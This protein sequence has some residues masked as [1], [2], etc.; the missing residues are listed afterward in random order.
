MAERMEYGN[1][2]CWRGSYVSYDEL[3]TQFKTLLTYDDT[4]LREFS[5]PEL[6]EAMSLAKILSGTFPNEF[7]I[8]R[9]MFNP[10][11]CLGKG[12]R[13]QPFLN[14]SALKLANLDFI[15]QILPCR[16]NSETILTFT[17][18]DLCGGPGGFSEYILTQFSQ[19]R[20]SRL[21][22]SGI[23]LFF[24]QGSSC[25]WNLDHLHAPP[26]TFIISPQEGQQQQEE[27][28]EQGVRLF[29]LVGGA[30]ST[31]DLLHRP[32]IDSFCRFVHTTLPSEGPGD[33]VDF[34]CG[35]GGMEEG[36]DKEDQELIH[37]PLI[38]SQIMAMIGTLR[39]GGDF[40]IKTFN[41]YKVQSLLPLP[42]LPSLSLT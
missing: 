30:D 9:G 34:V 24:P 36:R 42:S 23:S 37:L 20:R 8:A 21:V 41:L 39:P 18:A 19:S 22:G 32:N 17:W 5:N 13:Q 1:G 27:E 28:E 35:D 40:L 6:T 12:P 16:E 31:G 3:L 14:R 11:E 4:S 38:I 7:K 33:G 10:Y 2:Q 26:H 29:Y 15:F 25:N